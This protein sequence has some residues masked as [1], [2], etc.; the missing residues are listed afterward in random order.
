[1]QKEKNIIETLL[2][3]KKI[4]LVSVLIISVIGFLISFQVKPTHSSSIL[5][6]IGQYENTDESKAFIEVSSKLVQDLNKNYIKDLD[7]SI[8]SNIKVIPLAK[9]FIR[10]E[11][12]SKSSDINKKVLNNSFSYI[13][14]RHKSLLS[15]IES[16][17]NVNLSNEIKDN[18]S[19]LIIAKNNLSNQIQIDKE[20]LRR[21]INLNIR[22]GSA[23][24]ERIKLIEQVIIDTNNSLLAFNSKPELLKQKLANAPSVY[25]LIY[26]YNNDKFKWQDL[27]NKNLDKLENLQNDL[28]NLESKGLI[29]DEL[30]VLLQTQNRLQIQLDKPVSERIIKTKMKKLN[31]TISQQKIIIPIFISLVVG[32]FSSI[33]IVLGSDF[34]RQYKTL[35]DESF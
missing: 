25:G 21:K 8:S 24:D 35:K 26:N 12:F 22:E 9:E 34:I 31:T 14:D 33:F 23:I 27:K 2:Q 19:K 6:E 20:I 30:E 28:I 5:I 15:S 11:Y 16:I 10:I 18:K 29:S 13:E 4:I 1:M 17:R 3:S 32:F 7:I